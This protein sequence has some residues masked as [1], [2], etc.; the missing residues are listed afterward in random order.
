MYTHTRTD[1]SRR[2][3]SIV[4]LSIFIDPT[5]NS[6]SLLINKKDR[7]E[8]FFWKTDKIGKKIIEKTEPWKKPD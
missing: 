2:K 7:V 1:Q 4:T 5:F 8:I 6:L 3:V